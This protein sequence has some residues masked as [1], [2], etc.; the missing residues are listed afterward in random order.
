MV[1]KRRPEGASGANC[2]LREK[3]ESIRLAA[4]SVVRMDGEGDKIHVLQG[5][6]WL[7]R[8]PANGDEIYYTGDVFVL[9][10]NGPYVLEAI[11]EA[12]VVVRR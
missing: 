7:T 2:G 11:E 12:E 6:I 4:G 5:I 8:H 1:A 10:A 3:G 9:G